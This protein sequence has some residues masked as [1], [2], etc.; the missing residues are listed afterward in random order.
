MHISKE[1]LL[2]SSEQTQSFL[3]RKITWLYDLYMLRQIKKFDRLVTLTEQDK[4]RW[5]TIYPAATVIPNI[6]TLYP[7]EQ[8]RL[9]SKSIISVGRLE[10]QKGYDL[11]IEAWRSVVIEHPDWK[12]YIY[13]DGSCKALLTEMIRAAK[14]ETS[15]ILH[16]ADSNIYEKYLQHSFYVMSSRFEGF[17]L[18]LIEA[19]SCGLPCI[20]FDCPS[21]PAE[22]IKDGEDGILVENGNIIKLSE[23]ICCLIEHEEKR[24]EL[25]CNAR[26]N[27]LRF[28]QE[29]IML[30]W[31]ALFRGLTQLSQVH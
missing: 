16:G 3:L 5:E 6:L 2:K 28:S 7:N 1:A 23:A 25:G 18:V 31:D 9:E 20:S 11:L 24:K 15:F 30:Q 10:A 13:G 8:A 14:I 17:G 4:K 21:G 27:V 19:M 12:L 22:I 26:L 29:N